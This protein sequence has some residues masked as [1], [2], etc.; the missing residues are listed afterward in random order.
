M[1]RLSIFICLTLLVPGAVALAGQSLTP[2]ASEAII[3][4]A[5]AKAGPGMQLCQV[6][7]C[8]LVCRMKTFTKP[9]APGRNCRWRPPS[10]CK[11]YY[12]E[13]RCYHKCTGRIVTTRCN[14][15][16]YCKARF[17][18]CWCVRR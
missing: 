10:K 5:A 17:R 4:Q 9:C 3:T 14:N 18:T 8:V 2:G 6:K 11:C 16:G 1:K 13:K 15:N 7:P 12:R